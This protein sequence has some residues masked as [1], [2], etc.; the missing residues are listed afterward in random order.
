MILLID[1]YDSF[2]YNLSRYIGR[3][4]RERKVV[5]NNEITLDDISAMAPD[6]IILSPGPR[7]PKE[8][9]ICN[10]LIQ[11]FYKRTPILGICLG[12]QCIGESFG[13]RTVRAPEPVHGRTSMIQHDAGDL[14]IGL[15]NPMEGTRYHSLI[16][17]LA[18]N[19]PLDIT[20][21]TEDD[22]IIMGL[23]HRDYPLYGLQFHPE[24]ILTPYGLDIIRN[25]MMVADRWNER[26]HKSGLTA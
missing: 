24:S 1:N 23:R 6:A 3:L 14:F 5:R 4:G 10:Q 12:H 15:P 11:A 20:A 19:S 2:V 26:A 25:F 22:D 17:E 9:G 8:A 7:T 13:G 18:A 16:I 21:R